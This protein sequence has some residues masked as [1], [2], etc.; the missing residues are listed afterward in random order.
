MQTHIR[1]LPKWQIDQFLHCHS[2][3][4]DTSSGCQIELVQFL[5]SYVQE[6]GV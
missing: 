1:L 5:D 2:E 6:L 4:L 3:N